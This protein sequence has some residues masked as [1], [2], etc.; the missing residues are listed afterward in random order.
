MKIH[1]ERMMHRNSIAIAGETAASYALVKLIPA[2]LGSAPLPQARIIARKRTPSR[3]SCQC[4]I[5]D[6]CP[7]FG[8]SDP[9]RNTVRLTRN[10]W[11]PA[12]PTCIASERLA[13]GPGTL[14]LRAT[15]RR[16]ANRGSLSLRAECDHE[17][18]R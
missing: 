4:R 10:F 3:F 7:Q 8:R 16:V 9:P 17:R 18:L 5:G 14:L 6:P 1:V 11:N 13:A 12:S 2:G 15:R